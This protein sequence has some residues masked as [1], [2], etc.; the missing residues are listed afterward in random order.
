MS[1]TPG[2]TSFSHHP[3]CVAQYGAPPKEWQPSD[4]IAAPE[5]TGAVHTILVSP[6]DGILRYFPFSVNASIGDTI[7]YVWNTPANHTATLSSALAP[8]NRS[9]RA[10]ELKWAS[11]V[12]NASQGTQ[13]CEYPRALLFLAGYS[14][15]AP[16]YSR[17]RPPN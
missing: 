10:D 16:L 8:C 3:E 9:A 2:L 7:R 6:M 14:L 5:G 12:R 15:R 13:V 11:G 1:S 17:C 4:S